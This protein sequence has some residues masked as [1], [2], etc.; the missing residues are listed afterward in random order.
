MREMTVG[1]VDAVSG[2]LDSETAG[3]A[4]IGMSMIPAINV[5]LAGVAL[6]IGMGL[7]LGPSITNLLR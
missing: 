7:L 2:A 4:I 6:G 1:E 3:L 5:V